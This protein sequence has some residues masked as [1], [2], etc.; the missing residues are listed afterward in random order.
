MKKLL[1]T[2]F[3]TFAILSCSSDDK[4][5]CATCDI[6]GESSSR[7]YCL[8][9]DGGSLH[10]SS[11]NSKSCKNYNG[12]DYGNS[13]DCDNYSKKKAYCLSNDGDDDCEYIT[14]A[15][16][17]KS[18]GYYYGNDPTCGGHQ[19]SSS[20]ASSSSVSSLGDCDANNYKPF[21]TIGSQV[22]MGKNLNCLSI[23]NSSSKCYD[24]NQANCNK[25]GRLYTWSAAMGI[26]NKYNSVLWD[27][28]DVRI[29]GICPS[30][31]HIPSSKEWE[32]LMDF[33]DAVDLKAKNGWN[34]DH[35]FSNGTDMFDFSAL[36][37]GYGYYSEY[38]N[39]YTYDDIGDIGYWWTATQEGD[40]SAHFWDISYD[41]D[42]AD[43]DYTEKYNM[44]SVRCVRDY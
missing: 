2:A 36:P 24:D 8:Y 7:I 38:D 11:M 28:G 10:C 39:V 3:A 4:M 31:W 16:C 37:G 43:E 5:P 22:W 15:T 25:Y 35:D 20:S 33:V 32:T 13:S 18:G 19:Q 12:V 6:N 21:V 42:W 44:Y 30:G 17:D 40:D 27:K 1:F 9:S 41:S 29:K 23:N 34:T 14:I 26:V